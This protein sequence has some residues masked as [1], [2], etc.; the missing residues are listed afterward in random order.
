M[1]GHG[2]FFS[3]A[4]GCIICGNVVLNSCVYVSV[5]L[6]VACQLFVLLMCASYVSAALMLDGMELSLLTFW[7]FFVVVVVVVCLLL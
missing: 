2:L 5:H 3:A 6:G 1:S 4:S 7:M